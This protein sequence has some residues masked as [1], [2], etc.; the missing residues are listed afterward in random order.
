VA[1]TVRLNAIGTRDGKGP[2]NH[3]VW[4][5]ATT[6]ADDSTGR[7]LSTRL[8]S[9][10]SSLAAQDTRQPTLLG[11]RLGL[12][13]TCGAEYWPWRFLKADG[14]AAPGRTNL[15]RLACTISDHSLTPSASNSFGTCSFCI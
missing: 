4:T 10:L 2:L 12:F 15:K 11:M 5:V 9:H 7:C 1:P 6:D 14:E 3:A 13:A 8:F